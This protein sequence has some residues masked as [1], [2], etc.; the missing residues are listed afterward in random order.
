M[1]MNRT[2]RSF[3][4][5]LSIIGMIIMILDSRLVINSAIEG[6]SL[7][8]WTVIPS[9]FPF[10]VVS[11][12]ISSN[13]G[14]KSNRIGCFIS[15]LF[16]IPAGCE[17][18]LLTGFLGGYPIGAQSVIQAFK[19]GSLSKNDA[20]RMLSFCNNVGPAFIFGMVAPL[21]VSA[22]VGWFLWLITI[23]SAVCVAMCMPG[24]YGTSSHIETKSI[25][26]TQ[27]ILSS[28]K[29]MANVCGWVVL[30]RIILA[31]LQKRAFSC[32]QPILQTI[33]IGFFELTNGIL[34]T[35]SISEPRIQFILCAVF[36][37]AGGMC[38]A[39]QTH[40]IV[41]TLG[42][43]T[44]CVGKTLQAMFSFLLS[45]MITPIIFEGGNYTVAITAFVV[46]VVLLI[47]AQYFK[48]SIAFYEKVL[49]DIKN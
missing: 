36:L 30:F 8:L 5:T 47:I 16:K 37:N 45:L 20:L 24:A 11:S 25:P 3:V 7:C 2:K 18:V 43:R 26:A 6:I 23:L 44:Y 15:K 38:V 31:V 28:A 10:F 27:L 21:F 42:I 49:Y 12:L 22:A 9:L 35:A 40:S 32:V 4:V 17:I 41:N 13:I 39:L 33:L 48:K 1:D 19:N 34:Q 14:S 46:I 29:A